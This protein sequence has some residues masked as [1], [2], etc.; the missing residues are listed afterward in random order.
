MAKRE[1]I[2]VAGEWITTENS[3]EVR[4]PYDS[5]LVGTTCLG[6]AE[7]FAR[8][9]GA[10]TEAFKEMRSWSG[11]KRAA[12][13]SSIAD[14]ITANAEKLSATIVSE[15]GKPVKEARA[16]VTRAENTF[17]IAA[18]EAKRMGGEVLPLDVAPGADGRFGLL[19]N[20]PVG[21]VL[22]ISPFNF[23][24][25]LV[26]HKVAPA[27][28]VGNPIILKP[29]SQTPLS[30]LLLGKIIT[31]AGLISGGLSVIP[32]SG[33]AASTLLDDSRIK[34]LTFTGSPAVGWM[35]KAKAGTRK[36]TLEL[37]GNAGVIVM[38]D[39]D[40]EQAVKR[41]ITGA[42][43]FA[44]QVCISVQRIY[45]HKTLFDTFKE[46]FI[47]EAQRLV[48]GNPA[49][50]KTDLGP[51]IDP[52]SIERTLDWIDEAIQSGATLLTG[53]KRVGNT[54]TPTVLTGTTAKMKVCSNEIFAPVVTLEPFDDLDRVLGL[55]NASPF[56]LQAGLFTNDMSA[57]LKA[58]ETL[59]VGGLI[60]GDIPTF[61]TD[62]MPYGGVKS[63]GFGREGVKYAMEEMCEP[64]L[65][66]LQ[67]P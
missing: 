22:G 41:C 36:V 17:R 18:E 40:T 54:I 29:A 62:N 26:A 46:Y 50:E 23:P 16:E 35:L 64:K 58:Y 45:V 21:P 15:A 65:L 66:V 52:A 44:G 59:E 8:A 53:G 24:L 5:A 28:A 61:R 37:G 1:K 9:A 42:F 31:D 33:E 32:A 7:E 51:M 25:N 48:T 12:L 2:L 57:I 6:A 10:A 47:K 56:G 39:A 34:K 55:V 11:H 49:N 60:A 43:A 14:G 20:F 4:S 13:L 27:I 63:S 3:L 19:R 38:D 67:G 30:A